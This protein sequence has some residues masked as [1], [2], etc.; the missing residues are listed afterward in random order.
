MR[1]CGLHARGRAGK[2]ACG[3]L[4]AQAVGGSLTRVVPVARCHVSGKAQKGRAH[5]ARKRNGVVV[6][7]KLRM[8]MHTT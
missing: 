4:R 7:P 5:W 1:R 6:M 2:R 3:L 8:G